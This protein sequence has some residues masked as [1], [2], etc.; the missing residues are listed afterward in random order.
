MLSYPNI[1]PV[2]FKIGFIKVH[3]YGL[4]YLMGFLLTWLLACYRIKKQQTAFTLQQLTDILFYAACGVIVGGRM[5]YVLFYDLS[6][7]MQQ[8]LEIFAIWHGGMSFHGGFIGVCVALFLY[9]RK[10]KCGLF[11]LTDF[12]A[13]MV[14]IGLFFGRLGNFINGEL[15]GRVTNLPIG[16]VFANA[17]PYPRYPS[18]LLECLLEGVVLFCILWIKSQKP[19]PSGNIS[20]WFL[21]LYAIFRFIAEFFRAPDMQL[22]FIAFDWLTMGQLLCLPMLL[23]GVGILVYIKM[24][25]IKFSKD[26]K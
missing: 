6:Y 16:M 15:W 5:G 22:G 20:A 8:P 2:A 17:G 19:Q 25:D 1:D 26:I 24:R 14:P 23:L 9:S 7:F 13:P 18:Q 21:I 12:F 4:M 3:W 11:K 10:I